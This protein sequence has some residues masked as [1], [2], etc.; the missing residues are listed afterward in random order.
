MKMKWSKLVYITMALILVFSAIAA[1]PL[2]ATQPEAQTLDTTSV[3][4]PT[5]PEVDAAA[6]ESP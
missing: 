2:C 1:V 4:A 3:F 6:P 5:P